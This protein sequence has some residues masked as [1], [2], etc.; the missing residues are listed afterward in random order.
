MQS[1]RGIGTQKSDAICTYRGETRTGPLLRARERGLELTNELILL[2]VVEFRRLKLEAARQGKRREEREVEI[3]C[4]T[5][6]RAWE[7]DPSRNRADP[8]K[9]N[10]EHTSA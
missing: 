4:E 2:A 5:Q 6:S 10:R 8:R 7:R 3:S 9:N 1:R